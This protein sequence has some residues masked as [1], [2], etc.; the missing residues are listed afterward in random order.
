MLDQKITSPSQYLWLIKLL[1]FDYEIEYCKGKKNV[2]ADALSRI[3][4]NEFNALALS[5]V[6][7]SKLSNIRRS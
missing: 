3:A 7:T 2:A 1:G 4:N 5:I 6:F